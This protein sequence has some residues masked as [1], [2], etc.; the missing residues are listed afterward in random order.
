VADRSGRAALVEF[1]G[2]QIVVLPDAAPWHAATNFT[3][4]AIAGDA[5]GQCP[6]YD[7][8]VRRLTEAA[9]TLDSRAA[10]GLLRAV[11]QTESATQWSV[12]YG[13]NTGQVEVVVGRRHDQVHTFRL[14]QDWGS[15]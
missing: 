7:A 6:R 5:A 11:A 8:L 9:G 15:P 3:R 14:A 2:G 1:Y 4:S 10:L 12:V 13:M